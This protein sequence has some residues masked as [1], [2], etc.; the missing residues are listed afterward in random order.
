MKTKSLF[1]LLFL[2]CGAVFGG[3]SV[4]KGASSESTPVDTT[5]SHQLLWIADT[6]KM[7]L[8][9]ADLEIAT[10]QYDLSIGKMLTDTRVVWR[11]YAR[12]AWEC[13]A[14]GDDAAVVERI[15]QMLKLAEMYRQVG[16]LQNVSQGE[17]IRALAG[18]VV[19]KLGYSGRIISPYL[20]SNAEDCVALIEKQAGSE[21]RDARPVYWRH[22][23]ST[24]RQSFARLSGQP[25]HTLASNASSR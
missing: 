19:Q 25:S 6:H 17:E 13:A 20:E 12:Q 24:A 18:L 23:L 9:L 11:E 5:L 15:G 16:G 8:F 10:V 22:L 21:Q 3:N 14:K 4:P 7:D 2:S 1:A